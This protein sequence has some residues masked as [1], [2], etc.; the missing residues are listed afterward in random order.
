[1]T[2]TSRTS[3][4][5][6]AALATVLATGCKPDEQK[7][8]DHLAGLAEKADTKDKLLEKAA[9]EFKNTDECVANLKELKQEN[10]EAFA[11]ANTCIL[12]ADELEAAVGCVFKAAMEAE[13]AK[14]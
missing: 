10:E 3:L 7:V 8:C 9:E 14:K 2:R 11:N 13:K 5:A 12:D 4:V 1:M 6:L